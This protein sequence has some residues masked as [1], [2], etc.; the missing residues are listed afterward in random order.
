MLDATVESIS[1]TYDDEIRILKKK[2]KE[3]GIFLQELKRAN[4]HKD[5]EVSEVT[6]DYVA[7]RTDQILRKG[8]TGETAARTAVVP[9]HIYPE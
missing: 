2:N 1:K 3:S 8:E 5:G 9:D 6:L 7:T 4:V